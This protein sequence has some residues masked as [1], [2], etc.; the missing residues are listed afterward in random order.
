MPLHWPK[1]CQAESPLL[2]HVIKNS[3]VLPSPCVDNA[4][5]K[6]AAKSSRT[7]V[8]H[9]KKVQ[10]HT[11]KQQ[12]AAVHAPK[13]TAMWH[14]TGSTCASAGEFT[15]ACCTCSFCGVPCAEVHS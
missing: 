6:I 15:W 11:R 12:K 10:K 14:I 1:L 4:A 2:H 9:L 13:K 5:D 3:A 7:V 8:E